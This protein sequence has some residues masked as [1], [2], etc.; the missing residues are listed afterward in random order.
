MFEPGQG[1]RLAETGALLGGVDADDVDLAQRV[2]PVL[3]RAVHLRPVEAGEAVAALGEEEALGVEPGLLLAP[4]QVVHRPGALFRV[5]GE[6]G[7]VHLEPFLLVLPWDERPQLHADRQRRRRQ[8]FRQGAAHLPQ[9]ADAVEAEGGGER[10]R[11]R[12]VAV[13]PQAGGGRRRRP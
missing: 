1:E 13:S 12:V 11:A 7:G 4:Q 6:G 3:G 5:V 2:V 10:G 9:G 8:R